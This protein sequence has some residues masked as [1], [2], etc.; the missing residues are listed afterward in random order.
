MFERIIRLLISASVAY[1]KTSCDCGY[2]YGHYV[3]FIEPELTQYF[4]SHIAWLENTFAYTDF[5]IKVQNAESMQL[6][7]QAIVTPTYQDYMLD[8]KC[9]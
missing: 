5:S 2:C 6:P 8:I 7:I 9:S 1:T 4:N 3:F